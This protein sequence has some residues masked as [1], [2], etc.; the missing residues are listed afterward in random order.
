MILDWRD[1]V[2]VDFPREKPVSRDGL[3][4]VPARFGPRGSVRASLKR[5][6]TTEEFQL[7]RRKA[8]EHPLP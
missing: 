8:L 1:V 3:R 5:I 2:N 6:L 4:V 7:R